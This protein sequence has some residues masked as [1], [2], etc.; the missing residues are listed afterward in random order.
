MTGH[1]PVIG[2]GKPI[3]NRLSV[4]LTFIKI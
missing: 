3:L 4:L 1:K 2:F